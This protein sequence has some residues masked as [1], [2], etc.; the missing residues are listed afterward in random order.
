[1]DH[2]I[3]GATGDQDWVDNF[4]LLCANCNRIK[5]RGS[6]EA[7]RAKI[8]KYMGMNFAVFE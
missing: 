1:M 5:G 3:P 8:A 7:A 2:I 4:Q 6:Q